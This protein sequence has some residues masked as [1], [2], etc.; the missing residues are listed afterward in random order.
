MLFS[1]LASRPLDS[2]IRALLTV[3]LI[4]KSVLLLIA[5]CSPGPG[6]DTS[7]ALLSHIAGANG[8]HLSFLGSFGHHISEKLTRWDAIYYTTAARRDYLYEQEWAFGWGFT[9]I[10]QAIAS[11]LKFLGVENFDFLESIVG[12]SIAHA[13]HALSAIVVHALAR[14]IFP[15]SSSKKLAFA[16][17]CLHIFSPAGLFLSAPFS[18]STFA[19]L[20]LF[21]C[22]LFVWSISDGDSY[23]QDL[24]LV[25]SGLIFG[26]GTTVRSNGLL[27]GIMFLEEALRGVYC[28]RNGLEYSVIRRLAATVIGGISIGFFF[29]LPQYIAYREYCGSSMTSSGQSPRIWCERTLPSIYTFV[30]AHYWNVGF[31]RYWTLSNIPLFLL[32]TPMLIIL[33]LSYFW[34]VDMNS[35]LTDQVAQQD[36]PGDK[37][38]SASK[39]SRRATR[40]LHTLALPQFVLAILALTSYHVQ[41][42][43]RLSSGYVIWYLWLA[44]TIIGQSRKGSSGSAVADKEKVR[45]G[46]GVFKYMIM[47][48]IVQG[49]LFSSF[50]PPA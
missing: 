9:R 46:A 28:L 30:Q 23:A 39:T 48:A 42:I 7:T 29:V 22:L 17:A 40:L 19:L 32:A 44:A 34:T 4:W 27:S 33:A 6:Y 47:Y 38:A 25:I 26:V 35:T 41:I 10:I 16:A 50:L 37:L 49:G 12:I 36:V 14:A 20:N 1:S 15:A 18:E 43:S 5:T 31:L 24:L 45:T 8:P 13:S 2:P 3:F 21:G 11:T